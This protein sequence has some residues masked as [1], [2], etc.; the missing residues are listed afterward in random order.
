MLV[1]NFHFYTHP[2]LLLEVVKFWIGSILNNVEIEE[3]WIFNLTQGVS[4]SN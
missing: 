1:Y 2:S 4:K 3:I